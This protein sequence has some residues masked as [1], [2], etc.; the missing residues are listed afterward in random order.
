MRKIFRFFSIPR[1]KKPLHI[2]LHP[3]EYQILETL[4]TE[5]EMSRSQLIGMLLREQQ[6]QGGIT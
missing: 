5:R 4:A 3:E 2:S 6:D 1:S